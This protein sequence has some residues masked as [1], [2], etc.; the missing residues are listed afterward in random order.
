MD[1]NQCLCYLV[2]SESLFEFQMKENEDLVIAKIDATANDSPS[3]FQVSGFPTIYWAPKDNKKNPTKYNV[4]M[5]LST[6]FLW[7]ATLRGLFDT[8]FSRVLTLVYGP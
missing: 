5:L 8:Y 3:Q 1:R 7:P 6:Y 2:K 4:S